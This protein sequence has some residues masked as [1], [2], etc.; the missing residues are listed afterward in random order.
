MNDIDCGMMALTIT[1]QYQ[2]Q[3]IK[4][5]SIKPNRQSF[6]WMK[7]YSHNF[8]INAITDY[9]SFLKSEITRF[10]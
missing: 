4:V 5:K 6:V 1:P 3:S 7:I 2:I 9:R 10:L 8:K